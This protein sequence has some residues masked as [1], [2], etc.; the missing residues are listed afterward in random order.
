MVVECRY[1]GKKFNSSRSLAQH[2]WRARTRGDITHAKGAEGKAKVEAGANSAQSG[3]QS[4]DVPAT[5]QTPA[6]SNVSSVE[7]VKPTISTTSPVSLSV[8]GGGTTGQLEVTTTEE[9]KQE[10]PPLPETVTTSTSTSTSTSTTP[11]SQTV[12]LTEQF[13]NLISMIQGKYNEAIDVKEGETDLESIKRRLRWTDEDTERLAG[14]TQ[15]IVQKYLPTLLQYWVEVAF[16]FAILTVFVPKIFAVQELRRYTKEH[17]NNLGKEE[18][19]GPHADL[20]K[21]FESMQR[22]LH[23]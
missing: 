11:T 3:V 23:T 4:N 2:V 15:D 1:C 20:V 8:S 17:G 19:K 9:Y 10:L 7:T 5:S 14:P 16:G 6:A 13:R 12:D 22:G 21:E 18:A